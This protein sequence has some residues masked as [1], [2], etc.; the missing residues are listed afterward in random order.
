MKRIVL[1]LMMLFSYSAIA[2][3]SSVN[4]GYQHV[5]DETYSLEFCKNESGV[6]DSV[7]I[8]GIMTTNAVVRIPD[9]ICGLNV[10]GIRTTDGNNEVAGIVVPRSVVSVEDNAFANSQKL[11]R[12]EFL[13][14][15]PTAVG[16]NIFGSRADEIRLVVRRGTK[17]WGDPLPERWN[18]ARISYGGGVVSI[19]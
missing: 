14:D 6:Y 3:P 11:T 9:S 18:G 12:V 4:A 13:G 5:G 17:G 19:R 10:T 16:N 7:I 8:W 2:K 15:A 1:M